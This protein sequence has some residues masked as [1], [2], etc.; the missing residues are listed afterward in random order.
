LLEGKIRHW[1][2]PTST[3]AARPFAIIAAIPATSNNQQLNR[4]RL[5]IAALRLLKRWQI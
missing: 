2:N 1:K 3:A 4:Y 5:R